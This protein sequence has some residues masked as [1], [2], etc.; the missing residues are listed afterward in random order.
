[1]TGAAPKRR[2]LQAWQRRFLNSQRL[3]D[4]YMET[5]AQY[6]DPLATQIAQRSD[7]QPG[8]LLV[9][10]NGSQ[11]SG[12]ST[13][14][15]YLRACLTHTHGKQC[16]S[17][18][19]DDF[20]RTAKEREQLARDVHPLLRTRGVPGT[21]DIDLLNDTLASLRAPD[22]TV[23]VPRFDKSIDDRFEKSHWDEVVCP[24]SVVLLEGWCL[25]ASAQSQSE[26][27][28]PINALERDEDSDG[29][30]RRYVN[31]CLDTEFETLYA[32]VDFWVML[33]APGF[34]CV[35]NW[36]SEQEAK[37][38]AVLK[39]GS[40]GGANSL[41]DEAQLLRFIAHYERLTKQCLKTLPSEVDTLFELDAERRIVAT[42][43][44]G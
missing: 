10:V 43:R 3:P 29:S 18:S 36:R 30:W 31:N 38:R 4:A 25:G 40:P 41:M 39:E 1:M 34:E 13:L 7:S 28:A 9:G 22:G 17:L 21:H 26:L 19:L 24:I 8:C 14:C 35:L 42:R 32:E 12:K 44:K 33:S 11:G 27:A 6:F 37:L 5:A 15:E 16:V 23:L 20:Y 2:E